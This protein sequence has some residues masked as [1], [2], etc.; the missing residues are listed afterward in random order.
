MVQ[1]GSGL[2][3]FPIE[4]TFR[5]WILIQGLSIRMLRCYGG[6]T[7]G[8]TWYFDIPSPNTT[9]FSVIWPTSVALWGSLVFP[10]TLVVR[11]EAF[12]G[13]LDAYL[14]KNSRFSGS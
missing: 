14:Y 3:G 7:E 2:H 4:W 1:Q 6:R 5:I 10:Y 12:T 8:G 9:V 13:T 11:L